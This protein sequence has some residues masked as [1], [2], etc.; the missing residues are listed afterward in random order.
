MKHIPFLCAALVAVSLAACS[1]QNEPTNN[2]SGE[3]KTV[4]KIL[5]GRFSVAKDHTV[6]FAQGNLQYNGGAWQFAEE[7]FIYYGYQNEQAF[8]EGNVHDLF[9]FGQTGYSKSTM[10]NMGSSASIDCSGGYNLSSNKREDIDGTNWDWGVYCSIS[11]GGNHPGLWRTLTAK[12]WKYLLEER[13][14]AEKLVVPA[15]VA[16][17]RGYLILPDNWSCPGGIAKPDYES[18]FTVGDN[19]YCYE[20]WLKL[21]DAGAVFL[22]CAGVQNGYSTPYY[23]EF[24]GYY[25]TSSVGDVKDDAKATQAIQFGYEFIALKWQPITIKTNVPWHYRCAVRL[26]Q[27]ID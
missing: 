16:G 1:G 4:E 13:D 18:S 3:A 5:K 23:P 11:N 6:R 10:T 24:T 15:R 21:E 25:W 14:N 26:V 8:G 20:D 27:E 17:K 9:F 19:T 7:Q 2:E 12:E 22:P